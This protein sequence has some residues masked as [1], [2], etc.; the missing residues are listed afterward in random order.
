MLQLYWEWR[1]KYRVFL[2]HT[3]DI[4]SHCPTPEL[5]VNWRSDFFHVLC[6]LAIALARWSSF[7]R[8]DVSFMFL[9][10][11]VWTG[12]EVCGLNAFRSRKQLGCGKA[13]AAAAFCVV[14]P[15]WTQLKSSE[16][17]FAYWLFFFFLFFFF[18]L[19]PPLHRAACLSSGNCICF[20]SNT[21]F[22]LYWTVEK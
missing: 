6:F 22:K 11:Q 2:S 17:R 1:M 8:K 4:L 12:E 16:W 5:S 7:P 3:S 15:L 10:I 9:Y 14:S 13:A 18:L 19:I 20:V 21:E